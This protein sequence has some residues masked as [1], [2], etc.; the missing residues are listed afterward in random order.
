MAFHDAVGEVERSPA[1]ENGPAK[2]LADELRIAD[3]NGQHVAQFER[4]NAAVAATQAGKGLVR[5]P[6]VDPR[7]VAEQRQTGRSRRQQQQSV[8]ALLWVA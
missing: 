6:A 3:E 7:Q 1:G 4:V 2:S 8:V 5:R